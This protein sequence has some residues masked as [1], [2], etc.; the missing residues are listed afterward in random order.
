MLAIVLVTIVLHRMVV[1]QLAQ[2]HRRTTYTLKVLAEIENVLTLMTAAETGE[3]G[4]L[5]T[6]SDLFLEPY[7]QAQTQ[8]RAKV[9]RIKAL[10][11]DNPDQQR[12]LAELER[13]VLRKLDIVSRNISVANEQGSAA[14]GQLVATG[15]GKV[16]MNA[17]RKVIAEMEAD[18]AGLLSKQQPAEAASESLFGRLLTARDVFMPLL[19]VAAYLMIL[20][21]VDQQAKT[22]AAL[23]GRTTE[24]QA[25]NEELDSFCYTVAHDLRAPIRAVTSFSNILLKKY[26]TQIPAEAL[27]WVQEIENGGRKMGCLIDDLLAYS[28]LGRRPLSMA[29]VSMANLVRE[30]FETLHPELEGRKVD[31]KIGQLP[32]CQGDRAMLHQVWLNL[33]GNAIKYSRHRERAEIEVGSIPDSRWPI[34]FVS[35]NGVGFDMKYGPKLFKVFERLH[36]YDE[37]EGTGVG[38][39]IVKRIIERHGG[40]VWAKA[41]VDKGATFYFTAGGKGNG[42]GHA[43]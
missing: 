41:E 17:I 23:V 3:R 6:R 33:L 43:S 15:E 19:V 5:I 21:Y 22:T 10:T 27:D 31:I 29:S 42:N 14:A 9:Q 32:E 28:K 39:A 37:F 34:Y 38:L 4:F 1:R 20:H 7:R 12:R 13:L 25:S 40:Q 35:D 2:S 18:E 36:G 11:D 30:I 8:V 26:G 16:T 24:L